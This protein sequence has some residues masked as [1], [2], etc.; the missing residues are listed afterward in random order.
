[1][2]ELLTGLGDTGISSN[3]TLL[4]QFT[5]L[6]NDAVQKVTSIVLDCMDDWDFD[7]VTATSTSTYPIATRAL[8]ANQRDY[9]FNTALWTL[10]GLEGAANQSALTI[11]PLRITRVD[12]SYDNTTY[13][14][15]TTLQPAE[16]EDGL[17]ND[18]TVDGLYS[19]TNPFYSLRSGAIWIYPRLISGSGTIRIEFDRNTN[20]FVS[21]DTTAALAIDSNFHMLVPM[22]A[23]QMWSMNFDSDLA[24]RLQKKSEELEQRFRAYYGR[25]NDAQQYF[26]KD[27]YSSTNYGE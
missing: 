1:M 7:D 26:F 27:T 11:N 10:M 15:A 21:S 8:V 25:K 23:S 3:S 9:R 19:Q 2:C 13:H 6:V 5:V 17:G 24:E 4:K 22:F 16:I 12:L 14:R 18:T 20:A